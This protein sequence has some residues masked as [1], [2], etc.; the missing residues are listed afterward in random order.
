M[1]K[2]SVIQV[3][4]E[5]LQ[6]RASNRQLI[7]VEHLDEICHLFLLSDACVL[8]EGQVACAPIG[9]SCVLPSLSEPGPLHG[10]ILVLS[11]FGL[12]VVTMGDPKIMSLS[13]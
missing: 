3:L 13:M 10:G 4:S 7:S 6:I 11:L 1:I 9:L 12:S 2:P 8:L 5:K